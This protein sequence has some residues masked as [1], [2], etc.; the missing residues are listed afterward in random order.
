MS[1]MAGMTGEEMYQAG[2]AAARSACLR[3]L[4]KWF[5]MS[6]KDAKACRDEMQKLEPPKADTGCD[7]DRLGCDDD[8]L[9]GDADDWRKALEHF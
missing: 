3:T 9:G 2:Y 5:F 7:D 6:N 8:R 4:A 1:R